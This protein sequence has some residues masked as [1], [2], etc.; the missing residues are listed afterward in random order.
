VTSICGAAKVKESARPI[1]DPAVAQQQHLEPI[2]RVRTEPEGSGADSREHDRFDQQPDKFGP[3]H[4][5]IYR[6]DAAKS[7]S[8]TR[9]GVKPRTSSPQTSLGLFR[10]LQPLVSERRRGDLC[11]LRD[12][13]EQTYGSSTPAAAV[14]ARARDRTWSNNPLPPAGNCRGQLLLCTRTA[15]AAADPTQCRSCNGGEFLPATPLRLMR[16]LNS[17]RMA[18]MV[19]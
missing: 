7:K 9:H 19:L 17:A 8:A 6:C 12:R 10:A 18:P 14:R 4:V 3:A 1:F 2:K 15:H 16:A 11:A 5:S 13:K